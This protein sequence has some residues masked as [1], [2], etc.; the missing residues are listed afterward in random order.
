MKNMKKYVL[1]VLFASFMLLTGCIG[2]PGPPGGGNG[3]P[4]GGN[5]NGPDNGG[6]GSNG[7]E[8]N[9]P[10]FDLTKTVEP[11][12]A[13]ENKTVQL[14]NIEIA[15]YSTVASYP[16][17][18][19]GGDVIFRL[20]NNGGSEETVN[21]DYEG[22]VPSW[23]LHFFQFQDSPM[24]LAPGEE[25]KVH[26]FAS[27]DSEGEF[28]IDFLFW[29]EESRSDEVTANIKFYGGN[30]EESRLE[31]TSAVYGYVKDK[32]T[33]Q[34]IV[35]AEVTATR[36]NGRETYRATTSSG[37]YVIL[38]PAIGDIKAFFGSQEFTYESLDYFITIETDGYKYYYED[39]IS[40]DRGEELRHD[41][42]LEAKTQLNGYEKVWEQKVSE[43]YGFFWVYPDNS[44]TKVL[45]TQAKHNPELNKPTNFYMYDIATGEELW[46]VPTGN[47]CWGAD[48][49]GD[50]S[51]ATAGCGD[52]QLY[53]VN[54]ETGELKW[55]VDCPSMNRE[56]EISHDGTMV[57]TGPVEGYNFALL[58]SED[59]SVVKGFNT[60]DQWIRN[61]KFTKDDSKFA[62]G[63]SGGYVI[64]YDVETGGQLWT[65]RIGEFPLFFAIDDS[66]NVYGSGKGRILVSYD[67]SGAE[68]WSFRV[69]DHTVTAGAI[70][71]DGSR[72]VIGTVG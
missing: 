65:N 67:E 31:M 70:T 71:P 38:A 39:G 54:V 52:S 49:S 29:Q 46:K 66:G 50:G 5:P 62:V 6:P 21:V 58:D 72:V 60:V 13:G 69:A 4:N 27:L 11:P 64:M 32:V 3:T 24:T 16:T 17:L 10:D 30:Q 53:A 59:G 44:W 43:P 12:V 36:Y 45:A 28:S 1:A 19:L 56:S 61:S 26:Y 18:S 68:R 37:A 9:L 42:E 55:Q 7:Q 8:F 2:Q 22:D 47:E 40:P 57:L 48:I 41:I 23:N 25:K 33:G 34:P 35:G 20:K 15:Y 51:L 63:L 14:G